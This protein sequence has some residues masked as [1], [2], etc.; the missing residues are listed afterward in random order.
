MK[1]KS[2]RKIIFVKNDLH[3]VEDNHIAIIRAL[4]VSAASFAAT[5]KVTSFNY[6]LSGASSPFNPLAELCGVVEGSTSSPTFVHALID[7]RSKNPG[8]YNTVADRDGKFCLAVIT[9]RGTADVTV[10]DEEGVT[11]AFIK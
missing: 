9:Y 11:N 8:S 7:V 6:V 5:V 4:F 2:K 1:L 3:L 10:L